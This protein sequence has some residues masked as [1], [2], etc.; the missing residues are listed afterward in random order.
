M[1]FDAKHG[2]TL[3]EAVVIAALV[4]VLAFGLFPLFN[5]YTS[6]AR[7]ASALLRMQRQCDAVMDE[8]GRQARAANVIL[9]WD[10]EPSLS[11][12]GSFDPAAEISESDEAVS[13]VIFYDRGGEATGG[14]RIG[15]GKAETYAREE[16]SGA[17]EWKDL[18]IDGKPIEICPRRPDHDH[19]NEIILGANRSH[20]WL[21]ITFRTEVDREAFHLTVERGTFQCK[22]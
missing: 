16:G 8:I 22:L 21:N 13:G 9:Q 2:F 10:L 15:G 5:M 20:I 7:E 17:W 4:S 11:A 19:I 3:V 6:C 12:D 14:F 18:T 1:K